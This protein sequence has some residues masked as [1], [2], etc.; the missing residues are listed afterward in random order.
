MNKGYFEIAH[1][2]SM[3]QELITEKKSS[4]VQADLLSLLFI[5]VFG[6]REPLQSVIRTSLLTN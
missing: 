2:F 4:R 6:T 1:L 5:A 3:K